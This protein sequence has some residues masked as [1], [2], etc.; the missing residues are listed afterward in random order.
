MAALIPLA[1]KVHVPV[2]TP[3][4]LVVIGLFLPLISSFV[5]GRF[6]LQFGNLFGVAPSGDFFLAD[7]IVE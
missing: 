5:I 4:M 3:L 6:I 1:D 2:L 7:R